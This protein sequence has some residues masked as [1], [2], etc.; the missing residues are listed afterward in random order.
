MTPMV[1]LD[2]E[3]HSDVL[4]L[5]ASLS[6]QLDRRWAAHLQNPADVVPWDKVRS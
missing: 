3:G 1:S 4:P 6:E 2:N 5:D